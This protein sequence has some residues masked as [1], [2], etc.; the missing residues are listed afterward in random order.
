MMG[1][2]VLSSKNILYFCN[3]KNLT[4]HVVAAQSSVFRAPNLLVKYNPNDGGRSN[5][6]KGSALDTLTHRIGVFI[7]QKFN[8]MNNE[9]EKTQ[10]EALLQAAENVQKILNDFWNLPE[11]WKSLAK[12][13][14]TLAFA[15]KNSEPD[16]LSDIVNL[17]LQFEML[18]DALKPLED[19]SK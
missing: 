12:A 8:V 19:A 7:C 2:K 15:Q 3:V 11:L 10:Q 18:L 14:T 1:T 13:G 17:L 5:A 16:E 6:H 4:Q 9:K